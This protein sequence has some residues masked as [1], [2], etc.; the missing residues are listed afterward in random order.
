MRKSLTPVAQKLRRDS[1]EAEKCLWNVLRSKSMG[2]RFRRQAVIGRYIVDFVCFEKKLVVEV[3]GGQH[4]QSQG[5]VSR[6]EWLQGQ[7]FK[8]LRFWNNE[9]LENLD[10]VFQKIEGYLESPP[11]VPSPQRGR[12]IVLR[13]RY[14][15]P[16]L[17][18][19]GWGRV[20]V[21]PGA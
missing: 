7:G 19:R 17:D 8:V 12:V 15:Y 16:S 5:D 10:G 2:F 11:L 18:G 21:E 3:D 4:D 9:V 1:T 13:A 14:G 6:D 20:S